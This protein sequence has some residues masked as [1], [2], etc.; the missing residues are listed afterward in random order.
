MDVQKV[1]D[2][3][4]IREKKN[5]YLAF[6]CEVNLISEKSKHAI[7]CTFVLITSTNV[8]GSGEPA[9]IRRTPEPSFLAYTH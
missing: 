9:Q 6:S 2:I 1:E 4:K 7:F 8:E 5:H 3:K